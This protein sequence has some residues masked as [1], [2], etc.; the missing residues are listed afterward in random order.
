[1]LVTEADRSTSFEGAERFIANYTTSRSLRGISLA[2]FRT[3]IAGRSIDLE[4]ARDLASRIDLVD[5]EAGR[6]AGLPMLMISGLRPS[7][8][9]EGPV[10]DS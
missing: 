7:A 9:A 5:K 3:W 2:I 8:V 6:I 1:L 4:D 10:T